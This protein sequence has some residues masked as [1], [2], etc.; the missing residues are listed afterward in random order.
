MVRFS[1]S[2]GDDVIS[3]DLDAIDVDPEYE[4]PTINLD[5]DLRDWVDLGDKAIS[6]VLTLKSHTNGVLLI[7]WVK[8]GRSDGASIASWL[9]NQS[10]Q[11]MLCCSAILDLKRLLKVSGTNA[12]T[13][14]RFILQEEKKLIFLNKTKH[15]KPSNPGI[16]C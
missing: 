10:Q 12:L 6:Q 14:K 1:G 4:P 9:N 16:F 13:P 15:L 5:L 8:S 2:E 11:G 7:R 3:L